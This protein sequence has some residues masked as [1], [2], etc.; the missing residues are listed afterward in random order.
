MKIRD[1]LSSL[2]TVLWPLAIFAGAMLAML[3]AVRLGLVLWQLDRVS[4]AHMLVEVFR[5]GLRFDLV[6]VGALLMPVAL[7]LP[8]FCTSA[9]LL[10]LGK[11]LLLVYFVACF[12]GAVFM[13]TATPSFIAQ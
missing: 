2:L 3:S 9:T 6:L 10:R 4:A 1:E 7:A 5:Q 11:P 12:V 8:L 13:E